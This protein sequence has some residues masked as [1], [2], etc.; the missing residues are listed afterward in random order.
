[1]LWAKSFG[2]KGLNEIPS[3]MTIDKFGNIILTGYFYTSV[4]PSTVTTFY[5]GKDTLKNRGYQDIFLAKFDGNGIPVWAKAGGGSS[6][7]FAY[8]VAT[9]SKG[10]IGIAGGFQSGFFW[11]SKT[12]LFSAGNYD[13]FIIKCDQDG[14]FLW[15]RAAGQFALRDD[16]ACGVAFDSHDNLIEG[17]WFQSRSLFFGGKQLLNTQ[18]ATADMFVVKYDSTGTCLAMKMGGGTEEDFLTGLVVDKEDNIIAIGNYQSGYINFDAT[19]VFNTGTTNMYIAKYDNNLGLLWAKNEGGEGADYPY[20]VAT[21]TKNNIFTAGRF[22]SKSVT[23]GNYILKNVGSTDVFVAKHDS[24][25][26]VI[27]A[28]GAGG[29]GYDDAKTVAIDHH[30]NP[31]IGGCFYSSSIDFG[32]VFNNQFTSSSSADLYIAKIGSIA[33]GVTETELNDSFAIY[34]NP[35]AG[36]ITIQ[37]KANV[38]LPIQLTVFNLL[39]EK[40]YRQQLN[41]NQ[42]QVDLSG[43]SGILMMQLETT[44]GIQSAKIIIEH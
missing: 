13:P 22:G 19:T 10:N 11:N 6:S 39:G 29:D 7:D 2:A 9:D 15:A 44:T 31:V 26:D 23:L 30:G 42:T 18:E 14:K 20:A 38:S 35:S 5:I 34:P 8:G 16:Y 3:A 1:M 17:G 37:T 41:S 32:N 12:V 25:G 43:Y 27:W 4:S 33:T 28:K 40:I 24:K 36:E 21:D